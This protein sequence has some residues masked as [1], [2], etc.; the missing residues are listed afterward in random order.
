M[1]KS[2]FQQPTDSE[3]EILDVIWENGPSTVRFINERLNQQRKV[4]YTTTLKIMQIMFEKGLLERKGNGKSHVYSAVIERKN[5]QS[6]LIDKLVDSAF[7]GSA[8]RLVMQALGN[9]QTTADELLEIRKLIEK[10][11]KEQ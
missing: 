4:G 3:L 10:L 5:I 11:E 6:G 2:T 7:G 9:H 8:S 1:R